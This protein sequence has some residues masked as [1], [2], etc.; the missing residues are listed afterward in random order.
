[1]NSAC[2][3]IS[4]PLSQVNVLLSPSTKLDLTQAELG[5][6]SDPAGNRDYKFEYRVIN[7]NDGIERWV[8]SAGLI[9][10]K[11]DKAI[12]LVGVVQNVK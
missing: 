11:D 12:R 10:F 9:H 1:M 3:A 5:A 6:E 8:A 4:I 7:A 2:L